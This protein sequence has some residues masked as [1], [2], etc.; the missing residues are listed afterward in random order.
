[1][2]GLIYFNDYFMLKSS[3]PWEWCQTSASA[4]AIAMAIAI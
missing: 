2:D 1:M 3:N 4:M